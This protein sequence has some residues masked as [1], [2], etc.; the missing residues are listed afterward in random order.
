MLQFDISAVIDLN[1][2]DLHLLWQWKIY[3]LKFDE[4]IGEE[5][6]NIW[7]KELKATFFPE[8]YDEY[9]GWYLQ[10]SYES[11][12]MITRAFCIGSEDKEWRSFTVE[13]ITRIF[14]EEEAK[15]VIYIVYKRRCWEIVETSI[16]RIQ[17]FEK[18]D[19]PVYNI[20]ETEYRL[21]DSENI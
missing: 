18:W 10:F 17:D 7:S 5:Q 1:N 4:N 16:K 20:L 14:V 15:G 13:N 19:D 2:K 8:K 12:S 21:I 9:F 11:G 3:E 6:D